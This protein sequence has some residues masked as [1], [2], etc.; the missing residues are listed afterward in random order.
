MTG[1]FLSVKDL[2]V[3]YPLRK[4]AS[5]GAGD[6]LKAVDGVSFDVARGASLGIVGES[7]SGKSTTAAA[8]MRL[9]DL[10][11][12]RIVLDGTEISSLK[13]DA[14]RAFRRRMQMI[15]QDPYSSLNPRARVGDLIREPLDIQEIG[16][17]MER[18]ARVSELIETVGLRPDARMAFPHQFSGGQRQRIG[19]ARALATH[20]ELVVCDEPVSALDVA[21][22]AQ[23]LNLLK[24]LQ[25]DRGLT[26]VFI[27]HDLG[28]VR[29][30]CDQVVVMYRGVVVE[31]GATAE[32][33]AR[34]L[35]PYTQALIAARPS[36]HAIGGMERAILPSTRRD[37]A[38]AAERASA[39]RYVG[40][41]PVADNRCEAETPA[42]LEVETGR[43]AACF[44]PFGSFA[45]TDGG[46][47][48]RL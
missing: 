45:A 22:Q 44:H 7:G 26:Y 17:K 48:R 41:C 15:F 33:F 16:S 32:V 12:G 42:L 11:T 31:Q 30:M 24:R 23:I 4:G 10:T 14:L 2:S 20:P 29:Y 6:V 38:G 3:H 8:I 19:I 28:V 9:V 27:S 34:P 25:R 18:E 46:R 47:S 21:I 36:I 1:A 13:G 40:R 43:R 39:C 37:V 5:S 35:L